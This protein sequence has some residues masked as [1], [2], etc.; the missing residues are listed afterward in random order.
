[1][2]AWAGGKGA[3]WPSLLG[4][5]RGAVSKKPGPEVRGKGTSSALTGELKGTDVFRHAVC[6]EAA[7]TLMNMYSLSNQHYFNK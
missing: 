6:S 1:M 4:S 5:L 2:G 3:H 7:G